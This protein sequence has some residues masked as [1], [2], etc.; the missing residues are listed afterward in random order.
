MIRMIHEDDAAS[1]AKICKES[2]GHDTSEELLKS[3]ISE[4]KNEPFYYI[5]VYEDDAEH[6][7]RGFIQAQKYDLL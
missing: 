3:R 1:V 5:R 4:L 6:K 2:L 7:V